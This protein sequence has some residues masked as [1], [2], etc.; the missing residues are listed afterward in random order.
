MPNQTISS[1][2]GIVLALSVGTTVYV[3]KKPSYIPTDT[4]SVVTGSTTNTSGGERDD[5]EEDDDD[6]GQIVPP[7]STPT[8]APAPTGTTSGITMT[9]V[10][11]HGTRTS[12]W[13]AIGGS[14]YDLT[15]WIP[16]HP[17]GEQA[18]L[19]ICGKDGTSL[20]NGQHGGRSKPAA[21][22]VGF[23]IGALAK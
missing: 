22:L 6:G 17:G 11:Q 16:S 21:I 19:M 4:G 20:Y 5:E 12:C 14:V 9:V 8:T 15:S 18:I 23:K 1:I 3:T 2:V 10:A 13:S 7:V